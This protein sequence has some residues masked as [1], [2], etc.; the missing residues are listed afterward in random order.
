MCFPG[1]ERVRA[2]MAMPIE[3][4]KDDTGLTNQMFGKVEWSH[5]IPGNGSC[6]LFDGTVAM[7]YSSFLTT[8]LPSMI[9][10]ETSCSA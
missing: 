10:M 2:S 3:P 5:P 4:G 7:A 6:L 9:L 8:V 1:P